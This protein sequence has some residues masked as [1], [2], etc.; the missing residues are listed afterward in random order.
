VSLRSGTQG[1]IEVDEVAR[2]RLAPSRHERN[3]NFYFTDLTA[4]ITQHR[5]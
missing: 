2:T 1:V 3:P 4:V 5:G